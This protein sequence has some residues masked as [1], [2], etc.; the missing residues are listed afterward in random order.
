MTKKE[1]QKDIDFLLNRAKK[2]GSCSFRDNRDTGTSSNALITFAYTGEYPKSFPW[3]DSDYMACV[4]AA[5][6]LPKHRRTTAVMDMLEEMKSRM[7]SL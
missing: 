1:M 7:G 4:R 5:E 2:A 6:S 3:D